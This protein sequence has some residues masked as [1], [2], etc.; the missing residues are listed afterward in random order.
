MQKG[1]FLLIPFFVLLFC[2]VLIAQDEGG[3]LVPGNWGKDAR[4]TDPVIQDQSLVPPNLIDQFNNASESG[5]EAERMRL[6]TEIDSYLNPVPGAEIPDA[7]PVKKFEGQSSPDWG[8]GDIKVHDG[9]V[10]YLYGYRQLDL[11]Y[12]EDGRLYLAVNRR[13]VSPQTGSI[14][15]YSSTDGGRHW[16]MI[17]GVQSTG[18]Y[19][20]SIS[21]L[22]EK[23]HATLDDSVR[24]TVYY[25]RSSTSNMN[26]AK[27]DL[28]SFRRSGL[29]ST[30]YTL[31]VASPAAGYKYQYPSACSDGMFYS[32]ATYMHCIVQ[33]VSN[34]GAHYRLVHFRTTTWGLTHTNSVLNTTYNDFY[35]SAAFCNKNGTD[36]IYIAVERQL[37]ANE[38]EIRVINTPSTPSTGFHVY[39]ISG[40]TSGTKWVRPCITVQQQYYT[41]PNKILVTAVKDSASKRLAFYYGSTTGGASWSFYSLGQTWQNV[42]FTHCNSDSLTAGNGN[43]IA[44]YVDINGDSVSV[45]RGVFGNLGASY[46]S[47]KRNSYMSTGTLSPVCAI[48]KVGTAKYA[49]FAYAGTG[50]N[51]VYFN[52]ESLPSVGIEP[53]GTN[54]PDKYSLSQNYP[55]P[56]NP[57]TT[58][59]FS[60]PKNKFIKLSVFNILGKEVAVL[61]NESLNAGEYNYR[62]DA[63]KLTSGIYFYKLLTDE[64]TEVK[65]MTLVK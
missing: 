19:Y 23:R 46:N 30:W 3:I 38:Y 14:L 1:K 27:L 35:P 22:V 59:N 48:Y 29:V 13:N 52:Q 8:I 56:F 24:I 40:A 21:L 10:A 36:S 34:A 12:G 42:D 2:A 60:I 17:N 54:I 6:G 18:Q 55:N 39:Y 51:N 53:V 7:E 32:T 11:K 63:A 4:E 44:S 61:V 47:Y 20:G 49:S 50:P 9:N 16:S 57:V 62:F 31:N 37:N 43:F 5:N 64:F 45:R 15:V 28:V 41:V 26:D 65:K 58:I 33:Q 25:T